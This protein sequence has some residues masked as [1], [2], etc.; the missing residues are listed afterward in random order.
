MFECSSV[1]TASSNLV[2]WPLLTAASFSFRLAS[3]YQVG[4]LKR[5]YPGPDLVCPQTLKLVFRVW[6]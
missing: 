5:G 6:S 2:A 4:I 1:F 3:H